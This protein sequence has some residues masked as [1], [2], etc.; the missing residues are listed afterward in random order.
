M[1]CF[2]K[3]AQSMM[4]IHVHWMPQIYP[5]ISVIHCPNLALSDKQTLTLGSWLTQFSSCAQNREDS[6]GSSVCLR[7]TEILCLPRLTDKKMKHW[8]IAYCIQHLALVYYTSHINVLSSP[9]PCRLHQVFT[10]CCEVAGSNGLKITPGSYSGW[11]Y[12]SKSDLDL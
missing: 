2:F 9:L 11:I 12:W 3:V 1:C 10:A 4:M 5:Q 8:V 6:L 7:E